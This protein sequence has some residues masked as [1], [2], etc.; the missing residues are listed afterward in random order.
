MRLEGAPFDSGA[1][2]IGSG[3][4]HMDKTGAPQKDSPD[5]SQGR[6]SDYATARNGQI[7][8]KVNESNPG[9][10]TR[11]TPQTDGSEPQVRTINPPTPVELKKWPNPYNNKTPPAP[12]PSKAP[13]ASNAEPAGGDGDA[14]LMVGIV[15]GGRSGPSTSGPP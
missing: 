5:F 8:A 4:V 11:L 7:I 10:V 14:W 12:P 6:R 3:H 15:L 2:A 13:Q 9:V 1:V